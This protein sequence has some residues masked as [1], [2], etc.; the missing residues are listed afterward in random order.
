MLLDF[1]FK[2]NI[3]N[4]SKFTRKKKQI[5]NEVTAC[6]HV[7]YF[8]QVGNDKFTQNIQQIGPRV[9]SCPYFMHRLYAQT[10]VVGLLSCSPFFFSVGHVFAYLSHK[11]TL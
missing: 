3:N 1:F 9:N 4:H 8:V 6:K 5:K 7:F 10:L 11:D 2:P